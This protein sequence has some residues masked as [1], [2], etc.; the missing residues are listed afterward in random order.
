MV[1]E[2]G[3]MTRDAMGAEAGAE[4]HALRMQPPS[5]P[6][7]DHGCYCLSNVPHLGEPSEQ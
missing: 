2:C 6:R 5:T 1:D 7:Y 3:E 4:A